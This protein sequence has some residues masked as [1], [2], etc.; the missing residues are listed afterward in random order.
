MLTT[1]ILKVIAFMKITMAAE[2]TNLNNTKDDGN[3]C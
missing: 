2:K 3:S 1:V